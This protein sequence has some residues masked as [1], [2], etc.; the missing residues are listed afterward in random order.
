ML[1]YASII[2]CS[3]IKFFNFSQKI[4]GVTETQYMQKC[5]EMYK[6]LSYSSFILGESVNFFKYTT[7]KNTKYVRHVKKYVD[8]QIRP[9]CA[10]ITWYHAILVSYSIKFFYLLSYIRQV[11][12]ICNI[13]RNLLKYAV[14]IVC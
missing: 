3:K 11:R 1:K 5:A 12:Q 13:C 7:E 14:I 6:H 4:Y 9:K 2:L 10:K 8:V